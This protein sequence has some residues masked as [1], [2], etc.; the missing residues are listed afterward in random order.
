MISDKRFSLLEKTS[1]KMLPIL[2][3][4]QRKM[5]IEDYRSASE[6][7][8]YITG[9]VKLSKAGP[10]AISG[11]RRGNVAPVGGTDKAGQPP[12]YYPSVP[13]GKNSYDCGSSDMKNLLGYLNQSEWVYSLNIGNIM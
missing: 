4:I 3:E 9:P 7:G 12:N 5:A 13:L 8:N 6:G 1:V 10:G 2:I 11:R